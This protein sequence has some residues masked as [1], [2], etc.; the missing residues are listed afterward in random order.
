MPENQRVRL[1]IASALAPLVPL[2]A[3]PLPQF[4]EYLGGPPVWLLS[5]GDGVGLELPENTL[6]RPLHLLGPSALFPS[7]SN[8]FPLL[9]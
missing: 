2:E 9:S 7:I 4:R 3:S 6:S 1:F 5:L 8:A